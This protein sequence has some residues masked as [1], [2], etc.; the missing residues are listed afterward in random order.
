MLLINVYYLTSN[1][2]KYKVKNKQHHIIMKN[3]AQKVYYCE[4]CKYHTKTISDFKRHLTSNIH[5]ENKEK[6]KKPVEIE[7]IIIYSCTE[8]DKI[9]KS[10]NSLKYHNEIHEKKKC[11]D[12][13]KQLKE[14]NEKL[15]KLKEDNEKIQK[16][17]EKN[18]KLQNTI[19]LIKSMKNVNKKKVISHALKTK[20]WYTWI[21]KNIGAT[22]CSC[23]EI[24]EIT[25][26][27]FN[28]GYIQAESKGGSRLVEN[29]K[30]VCKSCKLSMGTQNMWDFKIWMDLKY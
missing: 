27:N 29:L 22:S 28:C 8:C 6:H 2:K 12:L 18:E 7:K 13:M 15:Q 23:C 24:N 21:G 19:K 1:T 26:M 14:I 17:K 3:S 25:Q 30:P 11:E 5:I 10:R 9:Y 16:L 20:V 4:N